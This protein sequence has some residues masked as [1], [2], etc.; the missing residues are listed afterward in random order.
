MSNQANDSRQALCVC[1]E[2]SKEAATASILAGIQWFKDNNSLDELPTEMLDLFEG[3]SVSV[4]VS[5]CDADSGNR[6][7]GTIMHAQDEGPDGGRVWLCEL[8]QFNYEPC[9]KQRE[10]DHD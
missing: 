7:F 2:D 5:T 10:S 8:D 1:R 3:D 4:D 6:V 9:P